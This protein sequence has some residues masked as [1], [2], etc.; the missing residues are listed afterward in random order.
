MTRQIGAPLQHF[1]RR[2]PVRPLGL[3]CNRLHAGPGEAGTADTDAIARRLAT[4]LD[5]IEEP[6]RR[7]DDDRARRVLAVVGNGLRQVARVDRGTRGLGLILIALRL[8]ED[9]ASRREALFVR[10]PGTRINVL[11]HLI[12]RAHRARL[13]A[14]SVEQKFDKATAHLAALRRYHAAIADTL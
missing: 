12:R 6:V 7:I 14:G 10:L 8:T 3:A 11:R 9:R 13:R 2:C 4:T 1:G 5:Q